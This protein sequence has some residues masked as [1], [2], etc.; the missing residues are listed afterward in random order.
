MISFVLITIF[1]FVTGEFEVCLNGG[2][3]PCING[4]C[5]GAN[6]RCINTA[7]GEVCCEE[8]QISPTQAPT[9]L[10]STTVSGSTTASTSAPATVSL[11][12]AAPVT[13]PPI[14]AAPVP[15]VDQPNPRTGEYEC[16]HLAHLCSDSNYNLVMTIQCPKTCGRCDGSGNIIFSPAVTTCADRLSPTGRYECPSLAYYCNNPIYKP[17]MRQQCPR[18]C[19]VC[20]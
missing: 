13:L 1:Q 4:A 10:A 2:V 16:A 20:R 18:T 19:G 6:E 12:T 7:E 3:G 14:T 5:T 8:S 17:L 15:C 9:T 11:S